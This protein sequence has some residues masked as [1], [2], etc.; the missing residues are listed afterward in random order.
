MFTSCVRCF[1]RRLRVRWSD[2]AACCSADF[3]ATKRMVGRVTASQIASAS[4]AS[5]LPRFT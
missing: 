4:T 5:F 1:T 2:K 3:T